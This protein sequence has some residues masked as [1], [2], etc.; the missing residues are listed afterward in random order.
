[1]TVCP[2]RMAV[3]LAAALASLVPAHAHAQTLAITNVNVVPMTG[4]SVLRGQTVLIRDRRI[5]HVGA[6]QAVPVPA[7]ALKIDGRGKYLMPGLAD[8]HVHLGFPLLIDP[9]PEAALDGHLAAMKQELLLYVINGVTTVRNMWGTR[10]HLLVKQQVAAGAIAGPRI[11]TAGAISDAD[12]RFWP[13]SRLIDTPAA[14]RLA[15]LEDKGAGFD[16]FK[17]YSRLGKAEYDTIAATAR[18]VGI[19]VIGHVS[20]N[21]DLHHALQS[22]QRSIEHLL[23]Y[24]RAL[25]PADAQTPAGLAG[26]ALWTFADSSAMPKLARE[27]AASGVWNCPTLTVLENFMEEEKVEAYLNQP[28]MARVPHELRQMW[29]HDPILPRFDANYRRAVRETHQRRLQMV[30]A[31]HD[32]GAGLLLGTDAAAAMVLPGY[33]IHAE[34]QYFVDAGL[35]PYEALRTGT[36]AAAEFLHLQQ[37]QG[38]IETGKRADLLLLDGNP[39]ESVANVKRLSGVVLNGRWFDK[40]ALSSLSSRERPDSPRHA[41]RRIPPVLPEAEVSPGDFFQVSD[42]QFLGV[43]N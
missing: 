21:I 29:H 22:R 8:M 2:G 14:A 16:F 25:L 30:K 23:G 17:V 12:P 9:K 26:Y 15:V 28:E 32:A 5:T 34:L 13:T 36:V 6:V 27:T 18:E 19:E 38:S 7:S 31:L 35:T 33:S 39:L 41:A 40:A 11:F 3:V 20:A 10:L 1:M 24:E 37:E 42:P 4:P 43:M